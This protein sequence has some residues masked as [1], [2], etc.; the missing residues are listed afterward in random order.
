[1][2][3]ELWRRFSVFY[4]VDALVRQFH[5]EN[6]DLAWDDLGAKKVCNWRSIFKESKNEL[7]T[8]LAFAQISCQIRF[9]SKDQSV[10]LAIGASIWS[11]AC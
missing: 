7:L 1:M 3:P 8:L 5:G 11:P 4:L 10:R 9:V 6:G 2:W